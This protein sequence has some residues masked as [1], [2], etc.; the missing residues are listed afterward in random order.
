VFEVGSDQEVPYFW[1]CSVPTETPDMNELLYGVRS[2][3]N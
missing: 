1:P 3:A 2:I